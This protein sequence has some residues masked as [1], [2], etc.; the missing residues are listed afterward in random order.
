M[1]KAYNNKSLL[2]GVPGLIIQIVGRVMM[3]DPG[4]SGLGTIV[5]LA[6]SA[7]LVTGLA[8]YA[9][10]KGRTPVW[11]LMGFL[12][13]IGLIV[14]AVLPDLAK[15]GVGPRGPGGAPGMPG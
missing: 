15:D 4:S 1:I 14:L 12:S 2:L 11:C 7:L 13:L 10:A 5:L 3:G 9:M 8:Y 6:G